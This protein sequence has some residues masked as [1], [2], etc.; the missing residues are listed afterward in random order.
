MC[1]RRVTGHTS[2]QY[3]SSCHTCT[4]MTRTR[5]TSSL[6]VNGRPLVFRLHRHPV[7]V[8]CLQHA[9]IVLFVG[10]SFACF[11]RNARC[12]VTTDLHCDIPTHK[13]TSPPGAAIFSLHK[14]ASPSG[15]N[16][17]YDEKQITGGEKNCVVHSICTGLVNMCLTVYL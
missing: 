2:I 3:S 5:S 7:Q 10:E 13:T 9:R 12:T 14:L 17:N 4:N 8:N 6:A 15:R 11:A 16:M 1:A